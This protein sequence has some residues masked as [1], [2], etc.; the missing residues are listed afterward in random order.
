MKQQGP[1]IHHSQM[2]LDL[3]K[4]NR[5][6]EGMGIEAVEYHGSI[7]RFTFPLWKT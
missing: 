3:L 7:R 2:A 4:V 5:E 1:A 6:R